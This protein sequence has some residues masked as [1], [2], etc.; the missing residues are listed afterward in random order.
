METDVV[1]IKEETS[2]SMAD[3][4][5]DLSGNITICHDEIQPLNVDQCD[6]QNT[7]LNASTTVESN[8]IEPMVQ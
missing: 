2:D 8:T 4:S 7:E 3:T 1:A 6:Q 5:A